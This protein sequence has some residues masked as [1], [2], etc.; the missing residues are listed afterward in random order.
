MQDG[1][2]HSSANSFTRFTC[3]GLLI[4]SAALAPIAEAGTYD[5]AFVSYVQSPTPSANCV[6]F[7]LAGV[8]SADSVAPGPWFA[9]P[10]TQ[11]GFSQM[12]AILMSVKL[13]ASP[14]QVTTTGA[15]AGGTC[16]NFA[17]VDHITME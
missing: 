5:L 8:T 13:A 17:G 1:K 16:G 4:A 11:N 7:Q 3:V 2:K 14:V 15:L 9:I 10:A 12:M 6:Y